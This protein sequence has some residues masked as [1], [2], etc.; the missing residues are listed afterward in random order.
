[1]KRPILGAILIMAL[2]AL[3]AP[4][5]AEPPAPSYTVT[6]HT[7]GAGG[8]TSLGGTFRL[9]ATIG[10]PDAGTLNGNGYDLIGGFW[11]STLSFNIG[12]YRVY[13]PFV[14]RNFP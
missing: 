11:S 6:R 8:G 4:I 3:T 12:G 1:M 9:S 2:A 13:V 14:A 7:I 10:Q 5:L